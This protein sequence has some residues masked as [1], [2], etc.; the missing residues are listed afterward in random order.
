[1]LPVC[2]A[3]AEFNRK[4]AVELV[5]VLVDDP[6]ALEDE[7]VDEFDELEE[8]PVPEELGVVDEPVE[9]LDE[10]VEELDE[11]VEELDESVEELDESVEE[12]DEGVIGWK[13]VLPEPNPTFAALVPPTEIV[14][15]SFLPLMTNWPLLFSHAATWAWP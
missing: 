11:P 6:D 9:E 15:V 4:L 2:S 3:S 12:L 13:K 5:D 1:V 8:L 14:A 10:P 7:P